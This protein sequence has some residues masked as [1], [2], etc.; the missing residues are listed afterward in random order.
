MKKRAT[1]NGPLTWMARIGYV[2]RGLVFLIVGSFALLAATGAGAQ[3]KGVADALQQLFEKPLGGVLLWIIAAGLLC[4]AGWRFLQAFF[5]ADQ[6]GRRLY[7]LMRRSSLAFSGLFYVA[8][9]VGTAHITIQV[10]RV[11]ENQ[12]AHNWTRWL[13]DKPLGRVI[14]VAIAAILVGVAIGFA[15][16]AIRAPYRRNLD[17]KA[18]TRRWAVALGSFGILT[19]AIVFLMIGAF[20]AFAAYH[21]NSKDAVGFSGALNVLR[22]QSYGGLLLALAGCGLLAFGGFEIVEAAARR[23]RA[24]RV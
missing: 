19:R 12:E 23:V 14:V 8:L 7:G 2:A 13:M 15:V 4:F 10:H 18:T 5:D 11:N 22:H 3:P 16:K 17:A 1:T 21:G 9:A 24:P 20:L 6:H